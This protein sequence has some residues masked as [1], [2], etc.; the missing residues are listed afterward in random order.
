MI[1]II[2]AG[3]TGLTLAY[4]LQ[5]A[6]LKVQLYEKNQVGG[7]LQ[8]THSST[9]LRESAANGLL[10]TPRLEQL[11][12]ELGVDFIASQKASKKRFIFREG[13]PRRWP[14]DR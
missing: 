3:F 12:S 7:L 14:S 10:W 13:R 11:A 4:E 2:G 1:H 9:H 6:G 8:T 5:K